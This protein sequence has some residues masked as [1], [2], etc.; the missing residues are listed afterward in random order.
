MHWR[1]FLALGVL[2]AGL[3]AHGNET[4]QGDDQQPD[5]AETVAE[6]TA[7]LTVVETTAIVPVGT[8]ELLGSQV[9]PGAARRLSWSA[10]DIFEGIAN[11]TP[12]L[13]VNGAEEGPVL[14]LTGAVHGDELNGIE[15]VRRVVHHLDPAELKGAVIGVPIVNLHGFRRASRYLP[16]R[17]DL[18]RFFPGNPKGSSA[19]RIAYSFFNE[20]IA[21]CTALVDLH[22]GSFHRTNL[23]QV[24]ADVRHPAVVELARGFDSMVVLHSQPGQGTLRRAAT[25]QGIPAI[26]LEAGE[27]MRLQPAEVDAGVAG[28]ES[29]LNALGMVKRLRLFRETEPVYYD[30]KWIRAD[31]GG[32]FIGN[33][34]L[35]QRVNEADLLGTITDP[36]TNHTQEIRAPTDGRVPRYGVE[37]GGDARLCGIPSRFTDIGRSGYPWSTA[38]GAR[39]GIEPRRPAR[40]FVCDPEP[41]QQQRRTRRSRRTARL[42]PPPAPAD[43]PRRYTRLGSRFIVKL[44]TPVTAKPT[45]SLSRFWQPRYWGIWLGLGFCRAIVWLPISWQL[46]IGRGIGKLLLRLASKRRQYAAVNIRLCFPELG[47]QAI[48]RLVREHFASLGMSII[49]MSLAWFANP[50][51]LRE[52]TRVIGED[53]FQTALAS[54]RGVLLYT[55]HFTTL[56]AAGPRLQVLCDNLHAVYREHNNPMLDAVFM[57]G[58]ELTAVV[59]PKESTRTMIRTLR[60]GA[61]IWYAPDQAYSGKLSALLTFFGEPAMTSNATSQLVRMGDA[62]VLPFWPRRTDDAGEWTLE[63]GAPL[64]NFPSDDADADTERLTRLLEAHIRT[65]PEQYYWVHKRFKNRPPPLPDVYG[66]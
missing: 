2:L 55:G 36:I 12:V 24:R 10:S 33:V 62:L 60:K 23:P 35:G 8:L 42:D 57:Y 30:S 49:E 41:I 20:V 13:A 37:P 46:K 29:L 44:R 51:R 27:P 6:D 28:I 5:A 61:S 34:K 9:P 14:C 59:I 52:R 31:S 3:T 11:S 48:D 43:G 64:D 56:E 58:R 53:H 15:I 1:P 66:E 38:G 47:P 32:I 26:T 17:R 63:F 21:H 19:A 50:R 54:G 16:D 7:P 18:N 65:C 22:T 4:N 39:A 25:E 40:G 45:L